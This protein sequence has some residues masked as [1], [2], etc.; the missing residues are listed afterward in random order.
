MTMP[1]DLVIGDFGCEQPEVHCPMEYIE[2]L[3]RS[4][5]DAQAM[6]RTNLKKAA[7]CQKRGYGKASRTAVFQLGDW[8]WHVYP[9]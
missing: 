9:R 2:W 4:I 8:V 3:R 5:R 7:K 1:L 6:A